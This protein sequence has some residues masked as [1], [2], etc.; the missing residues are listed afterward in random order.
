MQWQQYTTK[1]KLYNYKMSA[2]RLADKTKQIY[3]LF[4]G[5]RFV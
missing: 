2:N 5:C 3:S 4:V 1:V